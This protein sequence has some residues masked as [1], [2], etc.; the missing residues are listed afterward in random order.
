M[1]L[2]QQVNVVK[3]LSRVKIIVCADS[4]LFAADVL[5]PPT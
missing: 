2:V 1:F 3:V 5:A 4:T